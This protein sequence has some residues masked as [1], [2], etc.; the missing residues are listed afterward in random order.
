MNAATPATSGCVRSASATSF[1][2]CSIAGNAMFWSACTTPVTRPVSCSGRRPFGITMYSAIVTTSVIVAISRISGCR[3]RT[4]SRLLAYASTVRVHRFSARGCTLGS[5]G[6]QRILLQQ[7]RAHHRRQR[8]RDQHRD[9]D[10]D[11]QHPR[12]FVEQTSGDAGHQQQRQEHRDQRHG[13]RHDRETD[14]LRADFGG[15][16]RMLAL[17]DVAH[18]VLDHH[19]RIVDDE[20]GRDGQRHQRKV[21]EREAGERHHAERAEQRER[22]R[23][24]RDDRRPQAAQE[25]EDHRDDEQHGETERQLDVAHRRA[26]RDRAIRKNFQVHVGGQHRLQVRQ[27]LAHLLDGLHDVRARLAADVEQHG[28]LAVRPRGELIV[29]DAVDDLARRRTGAP[30]HRSCS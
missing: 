11:R 2:R 26:D 21:V 10:R 3:A 4:Q 5:V 30:A 24:A 1:V 17:L 14:F 16:L 7:I 19:D 27:C 12:E 22:H 28:G 8:Q 29:L 20:A 23:D 9:R 25:H 18:D 15:F 13:Q 6:G